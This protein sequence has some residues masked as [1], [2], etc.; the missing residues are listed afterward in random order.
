MLSQPWALSVLKKIFI[1]RKMSFSL[2]VKEF[3]RLSVLYLNFGNA[4]AFLTGVHW[5]AK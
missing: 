5:A 3:K 4:L 2:I 1:I